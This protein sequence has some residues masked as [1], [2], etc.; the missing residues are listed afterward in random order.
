MRDEESKD[1]ELKAAGELP[2]ERP[3]PPGL[4]E[5]I[6]RTVRRRRRRGQ[7]LPRLA[8]AA[9][10]AV[11]AYTAGWL[12]YVPWSP[13]YLI[14]LYESPGGRP[15]P[16][17]EARARVAEYRA[18]IASVRSQGHSMTGEELTDSRIVLRSGGVARS[19]LPADGGISGYFLLRARSDADAVEMT[20][21]CPHLLHGGVVEV[22][23]I[24][25]H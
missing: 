15:L 21:S 17:A 20:R 25:H 5:Q 8:A 4:E 16:P 24:E 2:R 7:G 9:A 10:I 6:V 3:A 1:H 18:W 13:D 11:V 12:S 19:S 14:V 22:R 23:R